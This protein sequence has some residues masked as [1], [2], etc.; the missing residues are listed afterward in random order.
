[1]GVPF[2]RRENVPVWTSGFAAPVNLFRNACVVQVVN[3]QEARPMIDQPLSMIRT[4]PDIKAY[5]DYMPNDW[6]EG[7]MGPLPSGTVLERLVCD[8]GLSWRSA[9]YTAQMPAASINVMHA[10][11]VGRGKFKS[12]DSSIVAYSN[13]ILAKLSRQ[14]PELVENSALRARNQAALVTVAA[15][16]RD[17]AAAVT[18]D[19]PVE[20]IWAQFMRIRPSG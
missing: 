4:D 17:Q 8:L 5:Q 7:T 9:S 1:M 15:E 3:F 16:F 12:P 2:R 13:A 6:G 20:P 11:M 14:I 18:E 19:Y 10:A